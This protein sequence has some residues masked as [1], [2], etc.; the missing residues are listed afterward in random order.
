MT[1]RAQRNQ[2]GGYNVK[3]K[4]KFKTE[5]PDEEKLSG[6]DVEDANTIRSL[7]FE[8]DEAKIEIKGLSDE[9]RRL[10][11]IE[12]SLD[13]ENKI[14]KSQMM[15]LDPLNQ[16]PVSSSKQADLIET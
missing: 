7:R 8:L 2:L 13:A 1:E 9:L 4:Y 10:R 16:K 3:S 12:S 15:Q 14:M 6:N 11:Q 5:E